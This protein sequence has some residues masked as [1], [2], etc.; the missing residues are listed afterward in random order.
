MYPRRKIS[1]S[2]RGYDVKLNARDQGGARVYISWRIH[3][4]WHHE[5]YEQHIIDSLLNNEKGWQVIDVGASYGMYTLLACSHSTVSR[6][7][8]I[9]ASMDTFDALR[10]T[11]T[12]NNLCER[13]QLRNAAA[14]SES[15]K[16]FQ[17]EHMASS[18]WNKVVAAELESPDSVSSI[19]VDSIANEL[20]DL[21]NIPTL[22]KMDIEGH[23]PIAFMGMRQTLERTSCL[24][25]LFEFHV[26]LLGH[27]AH[28]FADTIFALEGM[29]VAIV[30]TTNRKL[31][32]LHR[33]DMS[34]L[35][36]KAINA[37]H[38]FNL[39]NILL[40]SDAAMHLI[41]ESEW[42]A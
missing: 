6:I 2:Y 18:E 24:A 30:D 23:E 40:L 12:I 36:D 10:E 32:K 14:S 8:A 37:K 16:Y 33:T 39:Y 19:T 15:G 3:G 41:Q 25:V 29:N 28:E 9:E 26:G 1:I 35:I 27:R 38:P 5:S 7:V 4:T 17:V 22:V 20:G 11:I 13:V 21:S 42:S 31:Q 34:V